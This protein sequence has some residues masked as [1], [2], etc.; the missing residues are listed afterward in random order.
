MSSIESASRQPIDQTTRQ[1]TDKLLLLRLALAAIARVTGVSERWL[2]M[3]VNSVVLPDSEDH[4]SHPKKPCWLTIQLDEMW[5]FVDSKEDKQ[6]RESALDTDSHEIVG[7][8]IGD[9]FR[10]A[11]KGLWQSE[12]SRLPRL[13]HLLHRFLGGV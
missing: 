11:A 3:Y 12:P 8:F 13:R 5:S 2:Q 9:R 1:L 7:V 6:W 4:R 10:Q